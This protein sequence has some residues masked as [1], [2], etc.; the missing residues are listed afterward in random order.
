MHHQL[1]GPEFEHAP[2]D[3]EGHGSLVC[4]SPWGCKESDI[5]NNNKNNNTITTTITIT[6]T[7]CKLCCWEASDKTTNRAGTQ[8]HSSADRL[9]KDSLSLQPPLDMPLPI[10]AKTQ[11][12]L[13][14][15]RHQ[16]QRN[17]DPQACRTESAN[18]DQYLP[19]D[20][21]VPSPCMTEWECT[22]G[23][24]D[25]PYGGPLLQG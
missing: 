4:C 19:W 9:L 1:N 2:G 15:G 14:F 3:S 8:P 11:I 12:Y 25:I 13:P 20:Q 17:Y 5:L 24:Q 6:T 21:L 23:K 7:A 22:A 18:P 16:K 10:R